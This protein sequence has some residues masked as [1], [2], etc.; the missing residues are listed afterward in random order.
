MQMRKETN[1]ICKEQKKQWLNNRLKQVE[2]TH[3]Q[4]ETRKFFKDIWTFQNDRSPPIYTCK[5]ENGILKTD[6]QILDRYKQYFA[7]LVKTDKKIENQAQEKH[8]SE[9]EI[10]IEPPTYK[11]VNDTIKKLKENKAPGTDNIPAELIKY[12]GYILKQRM[13]K[14]MLLIWNKEQLPTERLQEIIY[15]IYKKVKELYV[16]T[17][18]R[19]RYLI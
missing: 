3:K 10:A 19:L 16:L 4:N 13:Y 8:I 18:D 5:D 15:P 9:N 7:Y 1:R 17:I 12:R 2:E 11:E 14:L 6:K